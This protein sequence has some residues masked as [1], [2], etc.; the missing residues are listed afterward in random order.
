[1]RSD[2]ALRSVTSRAQQPLAQMQLRCSAPAARHS[3]PALRYQAQLLGRRLLPAPRASSRPRRAPPVN[4][5]LRRQACWPRS[6]LFALTTIPVA[7]GASGSTAHHLLQL[8]GHGQR[9]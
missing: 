7:G 9:I 6:P 8:P 3:A 4:H 2:V 1:M 5:C